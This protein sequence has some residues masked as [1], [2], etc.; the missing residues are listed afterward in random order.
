M[1]T[2]MLH[3]FFCNYTWIFQTKSLTCVLITLSGCVQAGGFCI[4]TVSI[5][6][7][8]WKQNQHHQS[9][10]HKW[11]T[12]L[13]VYSRDFRTWMLICHLDTSM[14][15]LVSCP[16]VCMCILLSV[17]LFPECNSQGSGESR[18]TPDVYNAKVENFVYGAKI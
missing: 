1:V 16:Y 15:P 10:G 18:K 11:Q 5:T 14:Y 13:A 17:H 2:S 8:N 4:S 7:R 9:I 3:F 12:S 6:K